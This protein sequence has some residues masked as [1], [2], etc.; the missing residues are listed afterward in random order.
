MVPVQ[1][2]QRLRRR[3]P[4]SSRRR[5][6]DNDFHFSLSGDAMRTVL[7]LA[8]LLTGCAGIRDDGRVRVVAGLYPLAYVARLVGGSYVDVTD[9]TPPGAEPHEIELAPRTVAT[10]EK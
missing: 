4:E 8:L 9:L 6:V 7:V 5:V 1:Q 3:A 2:N 10:I